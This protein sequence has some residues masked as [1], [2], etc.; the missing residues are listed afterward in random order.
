MKPRISKRPLFP[1]LELLA[2]H[3]PTNYSL[4]SSHPNQSLSGSRI[5]SQSAHHIDQV[6][7]PDPSRS[8]SFL[9][10]LGRLQILSDDM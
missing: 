1:H 10:L 2:S 5:H 8:F 7:H 4:V 9:F 6:I 3:F